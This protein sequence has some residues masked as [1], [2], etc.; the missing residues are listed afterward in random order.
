MIELRQYQ[1]DVLNDIIRSSRKGNKR[2]ILQM[3]T[4]GGKTIAA[5]AL[6]EYYVSQ[7]KKVLFLAHRRELIIQASG[8]LDDFK[9]THGIIM[10]D[11]PQNA[12]ASVQVAS[13]DTLRARAL[14]GD[15]LEMPKADLIIIDEAHRSLSRTYVRLIDYYKHAL[16]IGLTATPVRSDGTGMGV[17]YTDMV[18]A[19]SIKELVA[20]GNLVEAKYYSPTIPDLRKVGTLAGDYNGKEL[21]TTMDTP[22]L[23]GD[24]VQSWMH[25]AKGKS[26]IV[27][28]SGVKHSQHLAECFAEAGISVAHLDGSTP[29]PER[30]EILNK[31]H[32]GEV[33]VICNCMVL[34]EGFDA[35]RA[36]VCVLARPTK[37]PSL[38]IQMVG[39][40][41][42]PYEGK[43]IATVIDHSGAVYIHGFAT[44]DRE[45][46]LGGGKLKDVKIN[47]ERAG[48]DKDE[49]NIICEGCFRTYA[50]SNICPTCGLVHK[51]KSAFIET[52]DAQ[53]GL[54][55]K[56]TRKVKKKEQYGDD[57]KQRFYQELL[58]WTVVKKKK[59]GAA[60]YKYKE[61]FG[62]W[63]DFGDVQPLQPTKETL[64]YIQHL[65]IK[66]VRRKR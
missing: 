31:F 13:I 3:A 62:N 33:T 15:K 30:M 54:V 35:P 60:A 28:A 45:W 23:V 9:V 22:K 32:S 44:D 41:L 6:I 5:A 63:P 18:Q 61:R 19:I 20:S 47:G 4:G 46:T 2:I 59:P 48:G 24:I 52:I 1:K 8:K 56:V 65:M 53:L 55:D 38:Y 34:T 10:A 49:K 40:V 21:A 66:W 25:I 14:D 37:S 43:D 39:R 26:T 11:M 36:E 58:G 57:F 29:N 42:R 51:Q 50:G 16:V 7:G 27:F 12:F 64:S 17:I